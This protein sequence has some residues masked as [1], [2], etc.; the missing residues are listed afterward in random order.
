MN[1]VG[2]ISRMV[3]APAMSVEQVHQVFVGLAWTAV[4]DLPPLAQQPTDDRVLAAWQGPAGAHALIRDDGL[5]R[6]LHLHHAT[7]AVT[8]V[9]LRLPWWESAQV[10][11]TMGNRDPRTVV[12]AVRAAAHLGDAC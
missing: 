1:T 4:D 2:Q 10:L 9:L 3:F 7:A 11:T 6:V 8:Q 12:A 5:I